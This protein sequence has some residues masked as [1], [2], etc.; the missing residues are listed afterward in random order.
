MPPDNNE[1]SLR[2]ALD[3]AIEAQES[4]GGMMSSTAPIG[5][6]AP[7]P[8]PTPA[9][10]PAEDAQAQSQVPQQELFAKDGGMPPAP[11]PD[12]PVDYLAD[13]PK[14]WKAATRVHWAAIPKEAREEIHKRDR[15]V[16]RIFGE[17]AN[18]RKFQSD[19][20]DVVRP[21][22]G[23]I[24]SSGNT[25][26]QAIRNL[27]DYDYALATAPPTRRAQL[28]AQLIKDYG[29]DIRELDAALSGQGPPNPVAAEVER[30]VDERLAPFRQYVTAQQQREQ[31]QNQ[32]YATEATQ[33]VENM[34]ADTAKFPHFEQV[35]DDMADLVE[36]AGNR[37]L[38]LSAEQAYT[39]AVAM[40]PELGAQVV[41][42]QQAEAQHR[43]AQTQHAR[44]QRA[45]NAS[46]SVAGAPTGTPGAGGSAASL[47]DTI[48]S[49]F[50]AATS[51]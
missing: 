35:R 9:P 7:T 3:S 25:P 44:A 37:G 34:A 43:T 19:M 1:P 12:Q 4:S 48:E 23:R 45:L 5:S 13:A 14:S 47:R 30:L 51:R 6:P 39:R 42:Q 50:N 20:A 2:D 29:I 31:M 40:N 10:A 32:G 11:K 15:E 33:I 49:A 16:F 38:Y 18:A 46:S 17:S 24:R 27:L 22:E 28:A 8:A 41:A 26:I 21:Y 36:I